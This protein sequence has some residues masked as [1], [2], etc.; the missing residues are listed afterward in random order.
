MLDILDVISNVETIY[1]TNSSL[2]VLKDFERVLDELDMYVYEN[3]EDGELVEGPKVERHWITA[4]FM[5]PLKK[6]PNPEAA[7]RLIDYDC[8]VKYRKSNLV[9]PRQ[10]KQPDD[11][12][13]GTKKGKIDHEPIWVVEI[14]MPK[15]LVADIFNGYMNKMRDDYRITGG[16]EEAAAAPA[17]A[18]DTT[19]V[20]ME[21]PAK[22]MPNAM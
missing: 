8:K 18:A 5:W 17:E 21:Q 22:G 10:V 16:D 7:K 1:N 11:F 2:S 9:V 3:W 15:T 6:M 13:P 19:A 12:R 4:S 20:A 14:T